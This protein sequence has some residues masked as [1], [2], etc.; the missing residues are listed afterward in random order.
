MN[1]KHKILSTG[2]HFVRSAEHAHLFAQWPVGSRV[3]PADVSDGDCRPSN[4]ALDE[5]CEAAQAMADV[6]IALID[7]ALGCAT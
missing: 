4:A 3:T 5:F 1:L 7:T 6:A 2:Y